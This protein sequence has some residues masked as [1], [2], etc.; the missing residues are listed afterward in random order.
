[1]PGVLIEIVLIA[2]IALAIVF[3]VRSIIKKRKSG[4]CCGCGS[5]SCGSSC[6]TG[7]GME[8]KNK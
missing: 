6:C 4:G 1:M 5:S 7:C 2:L 3:A 8:N